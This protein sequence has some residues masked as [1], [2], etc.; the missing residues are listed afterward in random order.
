MHSGPGN[1]DQG[2]HGV[3]QI[4]THN[5]IVIIA[6]IRDGKDKIIRKNASLYYP[7]ILLRIPPRAIKGSVIPAMITDRHPARRE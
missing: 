3:E 1:N 2:K 6:R 5:R 4:R 7:A